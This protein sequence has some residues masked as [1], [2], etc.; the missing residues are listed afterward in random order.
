[1]SLALKKEVCF[2]RPIK[3]DVWTMSFV[4]PVTCA[5]LICSRAPHAPNFLLSPPLSIPC[6]CSEHR[7]LRKTNVQNLQIHSLIL[8][9]INKRQ[10]TM[11]FAKL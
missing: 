8:L 4:A 11:N 10:P 5:S 9:Q 2:R 6:H 3:K 1:M 7:T